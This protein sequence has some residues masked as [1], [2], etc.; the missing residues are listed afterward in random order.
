MPTRPTDGDIC[1]YEYI[2]LE[3]RSLLDAETSLKT[4]NGSILLGVVAFEFQQV[5]CLME[6]S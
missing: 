1:Y 6:V 3:C 4:S 5:L 2:L